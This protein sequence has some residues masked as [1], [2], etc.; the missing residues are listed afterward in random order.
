MDLLQEG[1]KSFSFLNQIRQDDHEM[2]KQKKKKIR[3]VLNDTI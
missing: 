1:V 2:E 3:V